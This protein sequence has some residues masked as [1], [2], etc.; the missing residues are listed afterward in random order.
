MTGVPLLIT[1]VI[2]IVVM[3]LAISKLKLH[4][5]LAIMGVALLLGIPLGAAMA[6]AC[7]RRR[8]L[9][10]SPAAVM[11]QNTSLS[12]S[13]R[14]TRAKLPPQRQSQAAAAQRSESVQLRSSRASARDRSG[15]VYPLPVGK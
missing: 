1:F 5:F 2:A 10:S 15:A 13:G 12:R 14:C 7:T 3:I 11:A 9:G 8:R 6:R 4:P